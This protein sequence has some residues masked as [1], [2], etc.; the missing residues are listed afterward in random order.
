[1]DPSGY[2]IDILSG[3]TRKRVEVAINNHGE[4]RGSG[5]TRNT[6]QSSQVK[7]VATIHTTR[8]S[9]SARFKGWCGWLVEW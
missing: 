7:S 6:V 8:L 4:C 9:V 5:T 2:K 1:M 3:P